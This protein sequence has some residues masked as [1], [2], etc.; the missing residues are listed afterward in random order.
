VG[1]IAGT[2]Q[3][4]TLMWV[5]QPRPLQVV[6]EINEDD[7]GRVKAGQSALLRHESHLHS[8]LHADVARITPQG[9]PDT[10]TFRAYL[11]LPDD[12]PL[13]IGMSVEANIIVREAKDTLLLPAEAIFENTVQVVSGERFETRKV[14]TGIRGSPYIE[15]LDG[16][17]EEALVISPFQSVLSERARV[18]YAT[19]SP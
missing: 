7:I 5:G 13:M 3:D 4:E 19:P 17:T 18:R 1:E 16:L 6:A 15:V 12:T 2:G 14:T 9:D 8:G 11:D 10:K